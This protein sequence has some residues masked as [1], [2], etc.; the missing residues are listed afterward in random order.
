MT[1]LHGRPLITADIAPVDGLTKPIATPEARPQDSIASF[2]TSKGSIYTYDED[3][4][5]TRFKAKTGVEQ[6]KQDITVFVDVGLRDARTIAAAYLL[7][8]ST[9]KTRVAVVERQSDGSLLI[10]NDIQDVSDPTALQV[11]TFRGDR[12]V[13]SKPASI[14]PQVGLRVFDSRRYLENGATKTE[15]HLGHRVVSVQYK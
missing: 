15:R 4:H 5:T 9:E 8:S 3:G 6:P 13:K 10:V 11:V 7:R 14:L 12:V 2:I 1:E